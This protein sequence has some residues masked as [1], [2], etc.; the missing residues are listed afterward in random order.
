M[1]KLN[2]ILLT[3]MASLFSQKRI[4]RRK[5]KKDLRK[6]YQEQRLAAQQ[7]QE[8]E[9]EESEKEASTNG[10]EDSTKIRRSMRLL[11]Y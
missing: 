2:L 6:K 9:D 5:H 3:I 11:F 10:I 1:N 7:Q 8:E 4:A